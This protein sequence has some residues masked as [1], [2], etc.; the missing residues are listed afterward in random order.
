[1]PN[2]AI[3]P[4]SRSRK[5]VPAATPE[6]TF[7]AASAARTTSPPSPDGRKALKKLPTR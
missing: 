3:S 4:V 2:R 1:M 7:W 5:T 6:S